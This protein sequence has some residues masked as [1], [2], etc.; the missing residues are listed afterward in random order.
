MVMHEYR[1]DARAVDLVGP[2][3]YQGKPE[4]GTITQKLLSS[5]EYAC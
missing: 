3:V 2:S 1:A 5:K 4:F